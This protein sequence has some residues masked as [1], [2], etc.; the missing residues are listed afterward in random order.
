MYLYGF[1]PCGYEIHISDIRGEIIM[2]R[3]SVCDKTTVFG[4][5]VSH[6]VR[7]TSRKWKAN[8]RKVRAIVDGTPKTISVCT[9]CLRSNKV[10]RNV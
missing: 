5:N 7:R 1:E 3:C 10:I 4:N 8:I 6:S 2:A 9:R